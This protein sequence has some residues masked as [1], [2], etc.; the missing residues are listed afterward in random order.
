MKYGANIKYIFIGKTCSGKSYVKNKLEKDY[1]IA[2]LHT[3][4]P[5]RFDSDEEYYFAS[6]EEIEKNKE[7]FI[8]LECFN[9]W[10]YGISTSELNRKIFFTTPYGAKRIKEIHPDSI[11]CYLNVDL[12]TR[13]ERFTKRSGKENYELA[14]KEFERRIKT[15]KEQFSNLSFVD[16]FIG[17]ETTIYF[18]KSKIDVDELSDII[19]LIKN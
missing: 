11:I 15:E 17:E 10:Y 18:T 8:Y 4:R 16:V 14:L 5:K 7:N 9:D 3:S 19:K 2:K 6:K 1:L 12:A 13:R